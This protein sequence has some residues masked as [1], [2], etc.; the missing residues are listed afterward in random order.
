MVPKI[1]LSQNSRTN[2]KQNLTCIF[3]SV[4]YFSHFIMRHPVV[5]ESSKRPQKKMEEGC[6]K[7]QN[8]IRPKKVFTVL[9]LTLIGMKGDT[10]ISCPFWIGFCRLNFCQN[11]LNFW[12]V[13]ADI[14]RNILSPCSAY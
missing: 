5:N 14:N 12:E 11:F 7:C 9:T 8:Q 2:F 4:I 1:S 10:F 6:G 3:L 13:K